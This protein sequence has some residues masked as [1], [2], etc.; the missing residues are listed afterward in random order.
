MTTKQLNRIVP[1]LAVAAGTVLSVSAQQITY[2]DAVH[3]AGGNTAVATSAGGGVF[4]PSGA[5]NNQGPANDGLWDW[6]AFGNSGSIYQN[7]S[8]SITTFPADDAQRLVTSVNGLPLN[9]YNVY[10]YFWATADAWRLAASLTDDASPLPI[11]LG[12][13]TP[14][15]GVTRVDGGSGF[16]TLGSA[17]FTS[18]LAQ[19]PFTTAVMMGE[20]NRR[21]FQVYLGQVTGTSL[22][23]YVDDDATATG[24]AQ[25]TW[26]DGIGYAAVPEPASI[27]IGAL[28]LGGLLAGRRRKLG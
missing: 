11:Y 10:A 4:N 9:T 1:A 21:L 19:N 22:D 20:G 24:Q 17:A 8:S 14:G 23:V 7:I 25:R 13:P 15:I 18:S 3:G 5:L 16:S 6:R 26:Y 2:V 12:G 27:A 28:G